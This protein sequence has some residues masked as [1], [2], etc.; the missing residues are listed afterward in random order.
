[1]QSEKQSRYTNAKSQQEMRSSMAATNARLLDWSRDI[2]ALALV[3]ASRPT[4]P[5]EASL[6]TWLGLYGRRTPYRAVMRNGNV[7]LT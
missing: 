3:Q 1:M 7:M 2:E 6:V 5:G 4:M